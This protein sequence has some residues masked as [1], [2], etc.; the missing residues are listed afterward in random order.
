MISV[1]WNRSA[2][3]GST[4]LNVVNSFPRHWFPS[5]FVQHTKKRPHHLLRRKSCKHNGPHPLNVL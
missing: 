3:F 1:T 2:N 5:K 4:I